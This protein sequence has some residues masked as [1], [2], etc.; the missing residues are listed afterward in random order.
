MTRIRAES[1]E[2]D[3]SRSLKT[4]RNET[5]LKEGFGLSGTISATGSSVRHDRGRVVR[6]CGCC[7][8]TMIFLTRCIP[9]LVPPR[10]WLLP[11]ATLGAGESTHPAVR[12]PGGTIRVL[13]IDQNCT[14]R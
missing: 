10:T 2:R 5:R 11:I 3:A 1:D 12:Q 9:A 13:L 7:Q 8:S 14:D 6:L 4:A